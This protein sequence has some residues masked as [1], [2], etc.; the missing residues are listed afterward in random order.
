MKT[1][2]VE[3][4]PD[5][6]RALFNTLKQFGECCFAESRDD[7]VEIF[8][9][10]WMGGKPFHLVCLDIM[11]PNMEGT[12]L[13]HLIH[14]SALGLTIE[15]YP[16]PRILLT[17]TMTDVDEVAG[18]YRKICDCHLTKPIESEQLLEK[19]VAMGFEAGSKAVV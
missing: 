17:T 16:Q 8:R 4:D 1:L 7:G 14:A 3:H 10:A 11:M 19:L 12:E 5:C 13:L 6:R 18:C 2:I 15:G 9:E